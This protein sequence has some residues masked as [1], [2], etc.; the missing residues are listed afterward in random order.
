MGEIVGIQLVDVP[1]PGVSSA[2]TAQLAAR[3]ESSCRAAAATFTG[4]DDPSYGGRLRVMVLPGPQAPL[5]VPLSADTG[6]YYSS[7][8]DRDWLLC[9]VQTIGDVELLDSLAGWGQRALPVR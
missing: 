7:A 6:A 3:R 8:D 5:R 2:E 1:G 9:T 4:V